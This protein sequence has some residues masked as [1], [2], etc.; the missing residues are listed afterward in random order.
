MQENRSTQTECSTG[1]CVKLDQPF[2]SWWRQLLHQTFSHAENWLDFKELLLTWWCSITLFHSTQHF[3]F[4]SPR[5]FLNWVDPSSLHL[6][7]VT[8]SKQ[9]PSH[10]AFTAQSPA[11]GEKICKILGFS[12][13][14]HWEWHSSVWLWIIHSTV[15][16]GDPNKSAWGPGTSLKSN[17]IPL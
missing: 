5:M 13:T 14:V 16:N 2:L 12:K 10:D 15:A 6:P 4:S 1:R 9:Y 17:L 11:S 3:S 8:D 7:Q